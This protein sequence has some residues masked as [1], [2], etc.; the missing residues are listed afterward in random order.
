MG[1]SLK[2]T[3]L[4]RVIREVDLHAVRQ[5]ALAPFEIILVDEGDGQAARLRALLSAEPTAPH[6]WLRTSAA[7]DFQLAPNLAPPAAALLITSSI[8]V[9]PS[10]QSVLVALRRARA[11]TL[12]V[13][14]GEDLPGH[15][16]AFQAEGRVVVPVLDAHAALRIAAALVDIV[17]ADLR[18]ALARQLPPTRPAVFELTIDETARANATYALTSGLAE[19]VPVLTIPMNLGDMVVL[20]KNQ[21]MMSY[22]LVLASG[23]DGE[24]RKLIG[25]I[26]SVL[27]GGLLFRQAARQLVGLIPVAG[28]VPKVAIAYGGT[29]AIGRA[30]VAWTTEGREI[31]SDF[32]RHMSIEGL[33]RGRAVA[34]G[35]VDQVRATGTRAN[36]R[37]ERLKAHLPLRS[38]RA[39]DPASM[40]HRLE[41]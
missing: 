29:W 41:N 28:L 38:R 31:T 7:S 19:V 13:T 36:G 14:L 4:W 21:L 22:R 27:G 3:N 20:T 6:P 24:P 39:S 30:V 10:L 33:D 35:L 9:S 16:L 23:R 15:R 1:V 8:D 37:W 40:K 26:L 32:V 17:P 12:L 25:E 34:K 11:P 18:L 2:L 5:T